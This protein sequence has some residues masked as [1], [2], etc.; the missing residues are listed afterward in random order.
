MVAATKNRGCDSCRQ[1]VEHLAWRGQSHWP[2]PQSSRV[3]FM[4]TGWA[5]LRL[6]LWPNWV[7]QA[8]V[9]RSYGVHSTLQTFRA[10]SRSRVLNVWPISC[11]PIYHIFV[12]S[13]VSTSTA[14]KIQIQ[15]GIAFE[16]HWPLQWSFLQKWQGWML[17]ELLFSKA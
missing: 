5:R 10:T 1:S 11:R 14:L 17:F 7:S 9:R 16:R 15:H 12:G 4:R 13:I 2:L 6:W 8:A 3:G